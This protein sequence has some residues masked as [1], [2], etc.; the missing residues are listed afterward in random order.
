M[1]DL[2]L[3]CVV[4]TWA[5]LHKGVGTFT[6]FPFVHPEVAFVLP[7]TKVCLPIGK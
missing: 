7:E 6:L 2:A 4:L 1:S 5:K 3:L